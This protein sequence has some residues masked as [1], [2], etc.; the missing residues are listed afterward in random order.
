[1][2]L[3]LDQLKT[4]VSELPSS[5]RAQLAHFLLGSLE[6]DEA[7]FRSEWLDVAA[8]QMAE[9]RAS[10]AVGVPAEEVL[11]SLP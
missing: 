6:Q 2:N 10:E 9:A 1:M 8:Q 4:A 3:T 11:R 5:E 7:D